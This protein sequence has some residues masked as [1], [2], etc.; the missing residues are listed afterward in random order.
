MVDKDICK[1]TL[2]R[3]F[4]QLEVRYGHGNLPI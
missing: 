4:K 3:T 1:Q 2:R